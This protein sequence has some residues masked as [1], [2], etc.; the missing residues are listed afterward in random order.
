MEQ[1]ALS[2]H[3]KHTLDDILKHPGL[4]HA[5]REHALISEDARQGL[6]NLFQGLALSNTSKIEVRRLVELLLDPRH[7]LGE[8][9]YAQG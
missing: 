1:N 4:L 9:K 7:Q 2:D 5:I 6:D 3:A 8:L